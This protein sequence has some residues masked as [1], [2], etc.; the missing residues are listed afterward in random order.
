[1][2]DFEMPCS[3]SSSPQPPILDDEGGP[4]E[5]GARANDRATDGE[6][7]VRWRPTARAAATA[8]AAAAAAAAAELTDGRRQQLGGG[9]QRCR[10]RLHRRVSERYRVGEHLFPPFFF[11]LLR[12]HASLDIC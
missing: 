1:M 10:P 2:C 5:G 8:A 4:E 11:F 6:G 12:Y 3:S 9:G 7:R